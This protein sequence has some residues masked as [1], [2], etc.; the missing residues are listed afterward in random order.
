MTTGRPHAA[1][2]DSGENTTRTWHKRN[3]CHGLARHKRATAN[4]P[5]SLLGPNASIEGSGSDWDTQRRP[6]RPSRRI[7]TGQPD[8]TVRDSSENT[9]RTWCK[10]NRCHVLARPR[11]ATTSVPRCSLGPKPSITCASV[12]GVEWSAPRVRREDNH[13]KSAAR[14]AWSVGGRLIIHGAK[15]ARAARHGT[16]ELWLRRFEASAADLARCR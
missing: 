4:V 10:R 14:S 11:R 15:R 5:G 6:C 2:R 16:R 9:T 12:K 3:R 7:I 1:A 8:A 13:A